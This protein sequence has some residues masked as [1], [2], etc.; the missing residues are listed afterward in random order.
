MATM[1]TEQ[2]RQEFDAVIDRAKAAG[3]D[4]ETIDRIIL[5]REWTTNPDFRAAVSDIS[6]AAQPDDDDATPETW[7]CVGCGRDL[8]DDDPTCQCEKC[9]RCCEAPCGQGVA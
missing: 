5:A 6:W 9:E 7:H 3:A 8:P 2:A 1:T 4:S